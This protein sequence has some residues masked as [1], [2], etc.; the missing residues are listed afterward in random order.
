MSTADL[1]ARAEEAR[2]L[3]ST[4]SD[5]AD[6]LERGLLLARRGEAAGVRLLRETLASL[7]SFRHIERDGDAVYLSMYVRSLLDSAYWVKESPATPPGRVA[8]IRAVEALIESGDE[9]G[10]AELEAALAESV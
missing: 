8:R 6:A 10:V 9:A 4:R 1:I 2:R 5:F 7:A 3:P